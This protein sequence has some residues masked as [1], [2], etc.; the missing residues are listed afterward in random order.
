MLGE[1]AGQS[2]WIRV[3]QYKAYPGRNP[4]TGASIPIKSKKLPFL[5]C[6]KELKERVDL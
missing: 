5:K 6:G 3:K 4:K 2:E 1:V